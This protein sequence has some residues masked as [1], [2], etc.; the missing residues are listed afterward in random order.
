[1]KIGWDNCV[2]ALG[3]AGGILLNP[4]VNKCLGLEGTLIV[5]LG[6]IIVALAAAIAIAYLRAPGT[7]PSGSKA[8]ASVALSGG[9]LTMLSFITL[10]PERVCKLAARIVALFH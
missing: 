6:S 3:L 8:L 7:K 10:A 9:V 1:M 5:A 4:D 2:L